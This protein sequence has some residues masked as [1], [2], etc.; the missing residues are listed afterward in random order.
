MSATFQR[1]EFALGAA[2]RP[3]LPPGVYEA[4]AS[5]L[6]TRLVRLDT[7]AFIGLARRGPLNTPVL[8]E[9]PAGFARFF[10]RTAPG[11]AEIMPRAIAA[12][13]AEGGQRAVVVRC[14]DHRNARTARF[15]LPGLRVA[16]AP[17]QRGRPRVAARNPGS[18]GNALL[19]RLT[20]LRRALPL[21]VEIRRKRQQSNGALLRQRCYLAPAHRGLLGTT[22]RLP[23]IGQDG[24]RGWH[25]TR[26]TKVE[27]ANRGTVCMTLEPE[28]P[29]G[30][31]RR[32][33]AAGAEEVL[34]SL[35]ITLDGEERVRERWDQ[36]GLDWR[37]PRYLPR[38][39]GRRAASE[40]LIP[41]RDD[42]TDPET[43]EGS[44]DRFWG[45]A[46][47]PPG[48]ELLRP[49]AMLCK[50]WLRPTDALLA[51][52][53]GLLV[54]GADLPTRK[55]G[56]DAT[57]TTGRRVFLDATETAPAHLAED[58]DH[59]LLMFAGRPGALEALAG[60]DSGQPFSPIAQIVAPDLL[61]A[62]APAIP[63]PEPAPEPGVPCFMRTCAPP[64]PLA[65]RQG[66]PY[67]L[68]GKGLNELR[69]I[70]LEFVQHCEALGTRIAL[71]DTPPRQM[72]GDIAA[73][74]RALASDRSALYAPWVLMADPAAP[75]AEPVALPPSAIAAGI[76]ARVEAAS[77][78]WAA[79]ANQPL[80]SAFALLSDPGL[81]DAGFLHEQ[82][83]NAIRSTERG[84]MLMGSRT[85]SFDQEWTHISVRRL[86]DWL[87]AQIQHDLVW[88]PFEPNGPA[89]WDAMVRVAVKRLGVV[90]D[91][92]ALAGRTAEESYFVRCDA[93][94]TP[95]GAQD[96]GQVIMLAGVAPA[97]PAEF[98]VFQ[99]VRSGAHMEVGSVLE[100]VGP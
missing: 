34:V 25:L 21:T 64:N 14:M 79:P 4:R 47:D 19:L 13:F 60:W 22:L 72:P 16:D 38:L 66:A 57:E 41:P 83:V 98:I 36:A 5:S 43:T 46:E 51:A 87:K 2:W 15:E 70:Q 8:V 80:R 65:L 12:F 94:T 89:L 77:N 28:P 82:R 81:P 91:S 55:E 6:A 95:Q 39:I 84:L 61:H 68:L 32:V 74:R 7:A 44:P 67:P 62:A 10:G 27:A 3:G 92:G 53:D 49:S 35:D 93:T 71:L 11:A 40:A 24:K 90:H 85:T 37:H 97:V 45:N 42:G 78:P 17:P 31:R 100:A 29:P 56:R 48:S 88:A 52:P 86:V 9:S 54:L 18:W 76:I 96:A 73:W 75:R 58:S 50:A 30:F 69:A 63:K 1:S 23:G 26:V 33:S 59:R 20:A 99:L